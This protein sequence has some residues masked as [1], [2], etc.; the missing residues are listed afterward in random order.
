MNQ[1]IKQVNRARRQMVLSQ[2]IQAFCICVFV[3]LLIASIGLLVP[4]I[5]HL[6]M[7][8]TGSNANFWNWSWIGGGLGLGVL[9]AIAWTSMTSANL[10]QAAVE[11]DERFKLKERLSSALLLSN[12]ERESDAGQALVKD[13]A[14]RA[15]LIEVGEEFK[16]SPSRQMLLPIL[17]ALL[18]AGL[19]FVPNATAKEV[20]VE[21]E[22]EKKNVEVKT[23]MEET[24]KKI[25]KTVEE[26]EAKG[27][28]DAAKE[29]KAL[30]KKIDNMSSGLK[31]KDKKEALVKL[32]NVKNKVA[33]RKRQLGGDSKEL[34]KQLNQMKKFNDGPAKKIADA[35]NDGDFKAAKDAIKDLVKDLKSGKLTETEKKKLAKDL[36]KIADELGKLAQRHEQAK[37]DLKDKIQKAMQKGDLEKAAKLQ[38]KLEKKQQQDKQMQKMKE[39]AKKMQKCADCMKQGNGQSKKGQAGKPGDGQKAG[40]QPS[41]AEMQQALEDLQDIMDEMGDDLQD[42]EDLEDIM[43]QIEQAKGNCKGCQGGDGNQ[44]NQPPKWQDWAK[45]GGR[46]AGKR[47]KKETETGTYKSR[48]KGR[49][50]QGQTIVTGHADGNNITGRS[51]SEA[52]EI[53]KSSSSK[54]S[55]P[56]ENQKLPRA[57]REHAREYFESLREN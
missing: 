55:D 45:G 4:K 27:L 23:A 54:K 17:P 41:D 1:I 21:P 22:P 5:W 28:K 35:M 19:I 6:S 47:D 8:A 16:M 30:E 29:L 11:I 9:A 20:A 15:E 39:M 43:D 2:F 3:G 51:I 10:H 36:Q 38:Q 14:D 25:R 49:L 53:A 34:K 7:L 18:L 56:L 52:R 48:V 50:Q 13:A 46:G 40:N 32:N 37:K 31:E 24:R 57:Q 44:Q 42:L 33:D 26:M 12:T